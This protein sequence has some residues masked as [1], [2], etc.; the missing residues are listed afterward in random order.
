MTSSSIIYLID[1]DMAAQS[2]IKKGSGLMFVSMGVLAV[3]LVTFFTVNSNFNPNASAHRLPPNPS[4][5]PFA[6]KSPKPSTFPTKGTVSTS[7]PKSHDPNFV[8]PRRGL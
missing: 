8:P 1:V 5:T 7:A 2:F 6:T 4:R 3:L